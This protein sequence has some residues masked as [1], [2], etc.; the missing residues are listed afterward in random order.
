MR[1]TAGTG[2]SGVRC[3]DPP[4]AN[5]R[6]MRSSGP[7]TRVNDTAARTG[8][9]AEAAEAWDA[10]WLED[11]GVGARVVGAVLTRAADGPLRARFSAAT[12]P[13]IT[14]AT[15]ASVNHLGQG[16][17]GGAVSLEAGS[18]AVVSSGA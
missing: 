6:R 18:P 10:A 1:A 17:R 4:K 9:G 5:S 12:A 15:T 13:A 14:T 8:R 16:R 7:S 3:L 2:A 11:G